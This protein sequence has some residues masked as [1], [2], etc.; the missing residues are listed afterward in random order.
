MEGISRKMNGNIVSIKGRVG[1]YNIS[2]GILYIV[3]VLVL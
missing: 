1:F 3:S 2:V